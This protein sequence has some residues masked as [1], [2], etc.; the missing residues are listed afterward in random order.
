MV[1]K[2]CVEKN[3][4]GHKKRVVVAMS[5]G[6][7]SSVAAALLVEKGYEVIGI[8]M[9]IWPQ[10]QEPTP[11]G[12]CSLDT[13][14]DARGV[15]EG[16]GIP[17]YVVNFRDIFEEKVI[18]YFTAEYLRGRTPNPCIACNRQIKFAALLE[19]AKALEADY[20][21]TG[22]YARVVYSAE[23]QRYLLL[24]G[25]DERK[26]QSYVLYNLTQEQLAHTL[27]PL[28]EYTKDQIREKAA[29]LGLKV[30]DK[31]E[32]Q[33]ICFIPDHDYK[34]FLLERVGAVEFPP[35][36]FVNLQG[37]VLGRHRGLPFYTV[38]QRKGLGLA[39]GYPVYV[40]ALDPERNRVIVGLEEEVFHQEL[41][42]RDNNFIAIPALTEALEVQAKIRYTAPAAPAR[43]LPAGEGRVNVIFE[44]PQRAATPG[45]AVVYYQGDVVVGGSTIDEVLLNS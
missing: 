16:L 11:G 13:I 41:Y 17:F 42:A 28:G 43:I 26:D 10:A 27:F 21:A 45:Q 37:E 7:D 31:A 39:L 8:T 35:G 44:K 30:A 12:C 36:D 19:R 24:K 2:N 40:V 38:G 29:Q 18:D 20:L 15:A 1:E 23:V 25:K 33:E 9:Q 14:Q 5:G 32:S 4:T 3:R 34:K 22:H 6:V